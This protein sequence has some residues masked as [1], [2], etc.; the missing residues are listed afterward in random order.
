MFQDFTIN[1]LHSEIQLSF[2]Q[3]LVAFHVG[4]GKRVTRK[5]KDQQK[6]KIKH[7]KNKLHC[8]KKTARKESKEA[9]AL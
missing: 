9:I 7:S 8:R 2:I 1:A 4:K 6:R 3:V 5:V